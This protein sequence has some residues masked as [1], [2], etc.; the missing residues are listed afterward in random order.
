MAAQPFVIYIAQTLSL[1]IMASGFHQQTEGLHKQ[2]TDGAN[3][4]G[5]HNWQKSSVTYCCWSFGGSCF[6][7]KTDERL[8]RGFPSPSRWH[9]NSV[10]CQRISVFT[11]S[12]IIPSVIWACW[13][14][15]GQLCLQARKTSTV[16]KRDADKLS[17]STTHKFL[18]QT[19][20][21]SVSVV[22]RRSLCAYWLT[23]SHRL[24]I[25][26]LCWDN[27][28]NHRLLYKPECPEWHQE[29]LNANCQDLEDGN[30][31]WLW[32]PSEYV[33]AECVAVETGLQ[34][35]SASPEASEALTSWS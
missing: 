6:H 26:L 33:P 4:E 22:A 5:G 16:N 13:G 21:L 23:L 17:L 35:A 12:W 19:L 2:E 30:S 7:F 20:K 32:M 11:P 31:G 10:L 3:L 1:S 15:S 8:L 18:L 24:L 25:T 9:H 14:A 27:V 28:Q 29:C 34:R